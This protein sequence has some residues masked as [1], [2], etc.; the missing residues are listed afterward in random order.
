MESFLNFA[1]GIMPGFT[2]S[3]PHLV[4]LGAASLFLFEGALMYAFIF[5]GGTQAATAAT[6]G[7]P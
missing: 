2:H 6:Q 7:E 5:S 1:S 4:A 3:Y